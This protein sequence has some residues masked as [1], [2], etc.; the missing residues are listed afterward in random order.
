MRGA[1]RGE[2]PTHA[3]PTEVRHTMLGSIRRRAVQGIFAIIVA[4]CLPLAARAGTIKIDLTDMEVSYGGNMSGGSIFDFMGGFGGGNFVEITADDI[5]SA[6]FF[7][8]GNPVGSLNNTAPDGDDLHADLRIINVG[9]FIPK[10]IPV[11]VAGNNN[12]AF[13]LDFFG[14][15]GNFLSLNTDEVSLYVNDF[16]FFMSGAVQLDTQ[17][18]PFG[19]QLD[20]TKPIQFS[21]VANFPSVPMGGTGTQ[22]TQASA[23]GVLTITGFT[24]PEPAT[25]ALLC[26]GLLATTIGCV[27]RPRR[28]ALAS[29]PL[30]C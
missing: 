13:G 25:Y 8:D 11:P 7:V 18:L 27:R 19:L 6:D 10:N 29:V 15:T 20:P 9:A 12:F 26:T 2:L 3:D 17:A 21:F 5:T 14:D 16:F 24:V 1:A 30:R 28:A 4:G 22:I 23:S